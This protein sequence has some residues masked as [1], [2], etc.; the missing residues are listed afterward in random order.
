M[1]NDKAGILISIIIPMFNLEKFIVET[2]NSVLNQETT[3]PYEIIVIDDGST[4]NSYNIVQQISEKNKNISLFTNKLT[5]GVS[6]SRNTG[7]KNAQGEWI[8]FLDGDDIWD[9]NT[10]NKKM[11]IAKKYPDI[12]F[13]SSGYIDWFYQEKKSNSIRDQ[14]NVKPFIKNT[15]ENHFILESPVNSLLDCHQLICT[16]TVFVKN[17]L[18]QKTGLFNEIYKMSEDRDYWLRLAARTKSIA[19]LNEDLSWYRKR[20]G[21]ETRRGIPGT[22]WMSKVLSNLIHQPE[23]SPYR[24][25]ISK[26]LSQN[27]L[28]N[29]YYYSHNKKYIS[30]ISEAIKSLRYDISNHSALRRVI[31]SLL[32]K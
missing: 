30:A 9:I 28:N 18:V 25:K 20:T 22:I 7:L 29:S 11:S 17:Q 10:I 1:K 2:I 26:H 4:D 16:D 21:S 27:L 5:K 12:E 23:F 14:L 32:F 13:I 6:G 19:Y 24:K 31:A 8:A 15:N 3:L